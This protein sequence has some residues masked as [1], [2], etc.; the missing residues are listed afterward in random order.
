MSD[1]PSLRRVMQSCWQAAHAWQNGI[2]QQREPTFEWQL[3]KDAADRVAERLGVSTGWLDAAVEVLPVQGLWS[4]RA[5]GR[6]WLCSTQ[7]VS[8]QAYAASLLDRA[9]EAS[10]TAG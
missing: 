10:A 8:D 9:F 5:T 1:L 3:V 6:L 4:A 7:A 2:D